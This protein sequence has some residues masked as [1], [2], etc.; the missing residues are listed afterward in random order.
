MMKRFLKRVVNL[1]HEGMVI[2]GEN[3][4]KYGN[5]N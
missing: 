5:W 3:M 4:M 2:N 1:V